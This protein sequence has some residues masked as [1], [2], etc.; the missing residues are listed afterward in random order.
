MKKRK[1]LKSKI[2]YRIRRSRYTVFVLADFKDLSGRDQ[3]M[4]ALR[5]LMLEGLVARIGYGLYAR[6]KISRISG[7][8]LPEKPLPEL[9]KESMERL[10]IQTAASSSDEDYRSGRS[11]QVPTGRMIRVVKSR[12]SRKIGYNG[13]YISYERASR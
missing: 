11:T 5:S 12:V 4:R 2:A 9:G 1:S 10:K 13:N 8:P 3:V 7:K 6:T